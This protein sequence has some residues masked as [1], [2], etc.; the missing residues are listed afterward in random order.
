M[1]PMR[2]VDD[3]RYYDVTPATIHYDIDLDAFFIARADIRSPSHRHRLGLV[4]SVTLR[5]LT[6]NRITLEEAIA[7]GRE[8]LGRLVVAHRSAVESI[9]AHCL[10]V[11][12][13]VGARLT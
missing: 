4:V 6:A 11:F 2:W 13:F 8:L 5:D 1:V 12:D 9:G 10:R 7:R 3:V